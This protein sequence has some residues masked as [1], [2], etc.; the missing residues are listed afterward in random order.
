MKGL[1]TRKNITTDHFL[2][3]DVITYLINLRLKF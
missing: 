2:E 1:M 3:L